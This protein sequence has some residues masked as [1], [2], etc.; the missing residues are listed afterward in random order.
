M[1]PPAPRSPAWSASLTAVNRIVVGV[2]GSPG[3][4]AA[5]DFAVAAL[6]GSSV[7]ALHFWQCP[8]VYSDRGWVTPLVEYGGTPAAC[9]TLVVGSH[10][11]GGFVGLLLGSI[12]Q[13]C[14]TN[15]SRP[16]VVREPVTRCG[17]MSS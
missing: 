2:D 5:L 12:S 1:Q 4:Q 11:H 16:V 10:G 8:T 3:A 15:A 17:E 13:H 6:R 7:Q 9:S 14:I